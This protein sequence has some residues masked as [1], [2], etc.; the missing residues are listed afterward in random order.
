MTSAPLSIEITLVD[1]IIKALAARQDSTFAMTNVEYL[2]SFIE[3]SDSAM[4]MIYSEKGDKPIQ[5]VF[6]SF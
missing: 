2:A 4:Q 5:Y 6:P 3:L 1:A